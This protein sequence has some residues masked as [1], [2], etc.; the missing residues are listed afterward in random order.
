[1]PTA[2]ENQFSPFY[3]VIGV[4]RYHHNTITYYITQ[5]QLLYLD[6]I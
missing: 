2:L 3:F 6:K 1:M 4:P 5:L